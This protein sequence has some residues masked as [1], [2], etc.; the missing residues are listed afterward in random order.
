MTHSYQEYPLSYGQRAL[1]F[2][3]C[4]SP[5]D[6]S[7]NLTLG[8]HV[9]EPPDVP[10]LQRAL[11]RLADRHPAL[12]TTFA[13]RDGQPLQRIYE[14]QEVY[15]E[16]QDASRWS[17]SRLDDQLEQEIY[18][19]FD[20]ER[21]PLLRALFLD[22]PGQDGVL[23]MGVHHTIA[24]LW[25]VAVFLYELGMVYGAERTGVPASLKPIKAQY[26]DY[27]QKQQEMLAGPERERLERYWLEQLAGDLPVLNLP[28]DRPYP[29]R[30]TY[31]GASQSLRI[32]ASLTRQLQ[33]LSVAHDVPLHVTLLAAFQVLL[34]RYTGQTSLLVGSPR[35]GRSPLFARTIGYFVNPLVLRA[36]LDNNPA[37]STFL[38]QVH[39]TVEGALAH[40]DYPFPLLVEQLRPVREASR[41]PLFQVM[42][43]WQKTTRVLSSQSLTSFIINEAGGRL[44][45]GGLQ[46]ESMALRPR[47]VPFDLSLMM[48][49]AGDEL[50]AT[51]EYNQ[52]ILDQ[53]TV[54]RMLQHLRTLLE[55]AVA[56]PD[57][58]VSDMSLLTMQERQRQTR[59]V[60]KAGG[61]LSPTL[62]ELFEAQCKR[63]PDAVAVV[64]EDEQLTYAELDR[65]ANQLGRYVRRLIATDRRQ[66]NLEGEAES[67]VALLVE[68]SAWAVVALLGILKAGATYL[69]LDPS[70]PPERL[71]FILDDARVPVVLT[72]A[73]TGDRVGKDQ[74]A[75]G[76]G[77]R[78]GRQIVALDTAW[79]KIANENPAPLRNK[80]AGENLAY[81]IYTSGST[82]TPKGVLVS[83][84][85][86]ASHILNAARHF[87]L[88]RDDRVLQFASL[89]FDQSLEQIFVA[90]VSGATLVLRGPEVWDTRRFSGVLADYGLTVINLPPAYWQQWVADSSALGTRQQEHTLVPAGQLRLMI[91]GGDVM[92]ATSLHLWAQTSMGGARLLNAYGPTETTI[93]ATTFEI[94]VQSPGSWPHRIPIG[95][96]LPGRTLYIR[97]RQG[98]LAPTGV[99]GE[100]VLGGAHLAHGYLGRP[101]L[102]A[103]R[104]V[105]DPFVLTPGARMYRTGD[106]ARYRADE[107]VEFA[108]RTDDQ[109]KI[110]GFRIELGEVEGI[111]S[112]H[113][114]V[115]KVVVVVHEAT[116][117]GQEDKR[118]VA[119]LVPAASLAIEELRD[120]ARKKLPEY[121]VPA[122]FIVLEALPL[123]A[124]GKIDRRALP[125]PQWSERTRAFLAPRTPV[126]QE[127]AAL[128]AE[129]LKVEQVGIQDGFFELGG[130]SLL[131]IQ[132]I[133]RV[134]ALYAV[135]LPLRSLFEH[136]TVEAMGVLIAE[137]LAK[138]T[139]E[140]EL[141]QILAE[142]ESLDDEQATELLGGPIHHSV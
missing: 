29:P 78:Q 69:P 74:D 70:S 5:Q 59:P 113:P 134:R 88:M 38:G 82:G 66:R 107:N 64:C 130:H 85:A 68:R 11:Q 110:R 124:S 140:Q 126:E 55:N 86:I 72:D 119:Y 104:F 73:D 76:P 67:I 43:S 42:F 103:E 4:L 87:E 1:W 131:G 137:Q 136:P 57:S 108:G 77:L 20:L 49:E 25:S 15:F 41:A 112:Q 114:Q 47:I 116:A 61:A 34:Y 58:R 89:S 127:L 23:F 2:L 31:R 129:L 35:A 27:V 142:L 92:P 91:S 120:F 95:R 26:T 133:S 123:T 24:D 62:V 132:L 44:D 54:S 102:T 111:L 65:R 128:Y 139:D 48:G 84:E 28:T 39:Q 138:Q 135:D 71:A 106:L 46:L 8:A 40:G 21:G 80:I 99:F 122:S 109:V 141:A 36:D 16:Y 105:P 12:R 94:D 100:L 101:G 81:V 3:Q 125:A 60:P 10:A 79:P 33:A 22:R 96:P 118:L 50:S 51:L 63:A 7:Y 19:P 14:H 56:G 117:D 17:T 45:L 18:R 83:H 32:D 121:M 93:T 97:D 75:S 13:E 6:A 90:L 115:R 30:Q 9:L 37:F 52:S 53:E 98:H